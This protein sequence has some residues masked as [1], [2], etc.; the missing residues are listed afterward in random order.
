M[1]DQR[2]GESN[3]CP[4]RTDC[5]IDFKTASTPSDSQRPAHKQVRAEFIHTARITLP[6]RI[7]ETSLLSR[8]ILR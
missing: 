2:A 3:A 4:I 7:A 8:V 5:K 1:I 6:I